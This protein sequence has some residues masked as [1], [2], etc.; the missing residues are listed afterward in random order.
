[1]ISMFSTLF[2]YT[3]IL[4]ALFL[5]KSESKW[6]NSYSNSM[7]LKSAT[8]SNRIIWLHH[9]ASSYQVGRSICVLSFMVSI[10]MH[11]LTQV[12]FFRI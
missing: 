1:M 6:Q 7:Y 9:C 3:T 5:K 2:R 10:L 12:H 8:Y 11:V 4:Y